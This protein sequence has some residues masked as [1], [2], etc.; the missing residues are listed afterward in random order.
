MMKTPIIISMIYPFG[1]GVGLTFEFFIVTLQANRSSV[2]TAPGYH[3][4]PFCMLGG[5]DF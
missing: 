3:P 2:T 5:I 1:G 4:V